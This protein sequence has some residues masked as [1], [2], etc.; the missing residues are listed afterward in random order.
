[1]ADEARA[2][3]ARAQADLRTLPGETAAHEAL[4][5]RAAAAL[6]T[7]QA[8]GQP[9]RA[10]EVDALLLKPPW[11]SA[12]ISA[13]ASLGGWNTAQSRAALCARRPH[14]LRLLAWLDE[15]AKPM[16]PYRRLPEARHA[17][18][19]EAAVQATLDAVRSAT[20]ALGRPPFV[21]IS[22][23]SLG[24]EA[25]SAAAAG[26]SVLVCEKNQFAA[27][28]IAQ[29]A[30]AH[31]VKH[32]VQV[33]GVGLEEFCVA[34]GDLG[35]T[36]RL[37]QCPDVVVL[38]P[39]L[40]PAG[41]D[42][43]VLPAARAAAQWC[44]PLTRVGSRALCS[45]VPE[46][47]CVLG[48]AACLSAG[49]VCGVDLTPLDAAR[50]TAPA[51]SASV[52]LE[53]GGV[54]LSPFKEVVVF[55]LR[56]EKPPS[57][58]GEWT[59]QLPIARATTGGTSYCFNAMV[60]DL[61]I[62]W[63]AGVRS[64]AV[65]PHKRA[66]QYLEPLKVP[67]PGSVRVR[68]FSNGLRVW[69]EHTE[70][71]VAQ[72]T[73]STPLWGRLLIQPWHFAM[74][75]D[76]PRNEAYARALRRAARQLRTAAGPVGDSLALDVGCGSGLLSLLLA[77]AGA[78]RVVGIEVLSGVTDLGRRCIDANGAQA[79]V[80]IVRA[81]AGLLC[82]APPPGAPKA[83][84]LLA[85]LMDSGGLGESLLGLAAAARRGGMLAPSAHMLPRRLCVWAI[86]VN[87][88]SCGTALDSAELVASSLAGVGLGAWLR[89]RHHTSYS[90]IDIA[91]AH[92]EPLTE[93]I[94]VYDA[95]V[96]EDPPVDASFAVRS[97]GDGSANAV[98]WTWDAELDDSE[99]VTNAAWAART[100]W[101]QAVRLLP[102]QL[103]LREG[104]EI[105]LAVA[106]GGGRE[107]N[108]RLNFGKE[109]ETKAVVTRPHI[110]RSSSGLSAETPA[111][112][113]ALPRPCVATALRCGTSIA[114]TSSVPSHSSSGVCV[115][116]RRLS[117]SRFRFRRPR[118]AQPARSP[119]EV[120]IDWLAALKASEF[121]ADKYELR[122]RGC[123][124]SVLLCEAALDIAAQP[125]MFGVNA[126]DA[127]QAL[128]V[129]YA[130]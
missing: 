29:V 12:R 4:R 35:E 122:P 54:L 52:E 5:F 86:V 23:G 102:E 11:R 67:T 45:F 66:V 3:L 79:A 44:S 113:C 20:T 2:A 6:D 95:I 104:Q 38:A 71:F 112:S 128:R 121:I 123:A 108:F 28:S 18:W 129:L 107:L 75:R 7:L 85:E 78:P 17:P 82:S 87:L 73:S 68:A 47:F 111:F 43:R 92:Y 119:V 97:I 88:R 57:D 118:S 98:I 39:L 106:T 101:R 58:L 76:V 93:E 14:A 1:M 62:E 36:M 26:A 116:G 21:L 126:I 99:V 49:A 91:A 30:A 55:D 114:Y 124:E 63:R 53:E 15:R 69:F 27:R 110:R 103:E 13:V 32:A 61:C 56:D 46:R 25:A 41:C 77:K 83:S 40:D 130:G 24:V 94:L 50:W 100:H 33:L 117:R 96:G 8:A 127:Q 48:A 64:H 60:L 22:E 59:M 37:H 90:A 74:V 89:L 125:A 10:A 70:E 19:A 34:R 31:G 16:E 51:V 115:G 65:P 42:K 80:E 105:I 81:E 9:L 72:A 120:D 109:R 84:L